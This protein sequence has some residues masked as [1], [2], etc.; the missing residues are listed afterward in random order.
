MLYKPVEVIYL[1][2]IY[3]LADSRI[4]AQNYHK[5]QVNVSEILVCVC[6]CEYSPGNLGVRRKSPITFQRAQWQYGLVYWK[7]S[8][9]ISKGKSKIKSQTLIGPI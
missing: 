8:I 2:N 5:F 4:K 6:V 1:S 9:C 3:C 7:E